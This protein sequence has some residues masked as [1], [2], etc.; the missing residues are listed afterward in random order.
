MCWRIL[1]LQRIHFIR[2]LYYVQFSYLNFASS[3][4]NI[5]LVRVRCLIFHLFGRRTFLIEKIEQP[6]A[7]QKSKRFIHSAIFC[8]VIMKHLNKIRPNVLPYWI[9]GR[10][11]DGIHGKWTRLLTT[12]EHN[13]ILQK[14]DIPR[15][16]AH[17]SIR[18]N[19]C[20]RENGFRLKLKHYEDF[21]E[22]EKETCVI[23]RMR[24]YWNVSSYLECCIYI[25][26]TRLNKVLI[27]IACAIC[28]V[29]TAYSLHIEIFSCN[30]VKYYHRNSD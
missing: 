23:P 10:W 28:G 13:K 16:I 12:L 27:F 18:L 14:Y 3:E 17:K 30:N 7:I 25:F 9:N 6:D 19:T 5:I 8:W 21:V 11:S 2:W 29:H 4:C 22:P 15:E 24:N 20:L 26:I 1:L